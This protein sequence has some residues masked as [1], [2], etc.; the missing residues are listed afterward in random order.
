MNKISRLVSGAI[1][2]SGVV[3]SSA[4]LAGEEASAAPQK[5]AEPAPKQGSEPAPSSG[6]VWVNPLGLLFGAVGVDVGIGLTDKSSLNV[7][8]SYWSFDLLGVENTSIGVGAG[9]QYFIT[10]QNFGGFYVLP[11]VRAE[12]TSISFGDL[13]ASGV[14]V[15]PGGLLG[16]QWDWQPVSLR[17]GGGFHYYLGKVEAHADDGSSVSSDVGGFSPDLDASL[18]FTW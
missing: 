5:G 3:V 18:G 14:F 13:G 8:A 17:L 2:A 15:G 6:G 4:A 12:Y 1:V 9:W 10:G 16:Y 11:N 7:E